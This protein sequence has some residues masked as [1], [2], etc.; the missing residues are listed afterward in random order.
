MRNLETDTMKIKDIRQLRWVADLLA[1]N[2][3]RCRETLIAQLGLKRYIFNALGKAA[4][5]PASG[6]QLVWLDGTESIDGSSAKLGD[7]LFT[8]AQAEQPLPQ[9]VLIDGK[10]YYL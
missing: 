1:D 5:H 8:R 9:A 3:D 4:H 2:A 7:Y 6:A 10:K